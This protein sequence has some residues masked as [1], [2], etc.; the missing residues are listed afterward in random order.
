MLNQDGKELAAEFL[1]N[2]FGSNE[3]FYTDLVTE[4]GALGTYIPGTQGEAFEQEDP[5]FGGQ[6]IIQD[7]ATWSEQIPPVNYGMHTYAVDDILKV[8]MQNYL[9]GADVGDVLDNAQSQAETQ[10][11]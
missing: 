8:E 5:F 6:A 11:R 1:A 4:I 9:N 10:L 2:T 7:F 3:Q